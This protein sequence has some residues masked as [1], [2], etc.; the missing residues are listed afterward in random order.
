MIMATN[1]DYLSLNLEAKNINCAEGAF[2]DLCNKTS[3]RI[4]IDPTNL[5]FVDDDGVQTPITEPV[6]VDDPSL[7]EKLVRGEESFMFTS[8]DRPD[9]FIWDLGC[10]EIAMFDNNHE[11]SSEQKEKLMVDGSLSVHRDEVST[12]LGVVISYGKLLILRSEYEKLEAHQAAIKRRNFSNAIRELEFDGQAEAKRND[13]KDSQAETVGD[14]GT[15]SDKKKAKKQKGEADRSRTEHFIEW[16]S[17]TNYDG[18]RTH[19]WLQDELRRAKPDL[20]GSN[21]QTFNKWLQTSEGI[22]AKKLL[23]RLK[24]EARQAG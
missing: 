13:G 21:E 16:A 22:P 4:F 12:G 15:G 20:W 9:D 19:Y 23:D 17:R 3:L 2:I 11:L 10:F 1:W 24:R 7:L 8:L 18:K 14:A 5:V 6:L